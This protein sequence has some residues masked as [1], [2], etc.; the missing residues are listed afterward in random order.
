MELEEEES[1]KLQALSHK[2]SKENPNNTLI[3]I[4]ILSSALSHNPNCWGSLN[5]ITVRLANL[6]LYDSALHYAKRAVIVIPD[7]KM[8]WENFWH[9]SSLIIS[10]LKH[11]SL[12]LKRKNEINDFLQKEF[13]DKRM[14][15]PR[16]KNDDI[17]LRVMK[18]PLHADNLYSKGEIQFT[19]T[20]IYRETSDLAR[21]DP[22]ENR[23]IHIDLVTEDKP[24]VIDNSVTVFNIGGDKISMGGPGKGTVFE[25]SIEAG[26]M[27][28]VACFTLVTKDNVEQFL[29]NYDE[30]KFGTEAVI[31][32]NALKF[33]GKVIGSLAENG[34][35]NIKSGSVTYMREE[36]LKL[37]S[38][39]SN[40]YL[41][42]K[43]PYSIE[44]E[45][46]FS[47]RNT[48]K[49]EIIEIGSIKDISVRIKTKEIKK[50]IKHHFELD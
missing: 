27:E 6:K 21:K 25:A 44:Q 1:K 49:P 32:T 42:N 18:K 3:P 33:R 36:D 47:Y 39:I 41:K 48:N 17:L 34:K 24:L 15:I 26:G 8:S 28:S 7:E 2:A 22:D 30:S 38:A 9:V 10:S 40:P 23:P 43:D 29:S 12:Q 14:A 31:I 20:R 50:W 16:L 45:Y 5:D 19:P 46:R 35:H 13:I 11:E 37:F 4:Q